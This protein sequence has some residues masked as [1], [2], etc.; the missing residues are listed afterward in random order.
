MSL[1]LFFR[2]CLL[3][4]PRVHAYVDG[5]HQHGTTTHLPSSHTP[6]RVGKDAGKKVSRPPPVGAPVLRSSHHGSSRSTLLR[7][8]QCAR[9]SFVCFVTL[10]WCVCVCVCVCVRTRNLLECVAWRRTLYVC[11]RLHAWSVESAVVVC[12]I[13]SC[14]C[15][16][17]CVFYV[18]PLC[19]AV[20]RQNLINIRAAPGGST[21]DGL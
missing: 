6:S 5:M 10:Q 16:P 19:C 4:C 13:Y 21:E 9:L 15:V 8:H 14:L 12:P 1:W 2:H 20:F 11:M 3:I 18:F 17:T 7:A